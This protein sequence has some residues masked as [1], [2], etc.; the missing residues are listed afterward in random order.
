MLRVKTIPFKESTQFLGMTLDCRLNWE[1]QI[2]S[3][4]KNS[5]KCYKDSS[6]KKWEGDWKTLKNCTVQYVEYSRTMADNFITQFLQ[7]D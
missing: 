4:S 2:E 1:E 5:I 7:E 3:Q 6:R